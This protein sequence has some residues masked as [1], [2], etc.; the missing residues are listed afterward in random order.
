MP[1]QVLE[2]STRSTKWED[3][4]VLCPQ[5]D[6]DGSAYLGRHRERAPAGIA[7]APS[8]SRRRDVDVD[9]IVVQDQSSRSRGARGGPRRSCRSGSDRY[10]PRVADV[11]A[12]DVDD[13]VDA[14]EHRQVNRAI[15]AA[16]R[17]SRPD[18]RCP[19]Q[20]LEKSTRSRKKRTPVSRAR[21]NTSTSAYSAVCGNAR[22]AGVEQAA[23]HPRRRDV[24]VDARRSGA[25]RHVLAQHAVAPGVVVGRV[26]IVGPRVAD[27][28][29]QGSFR[30]RRRHPRASADQSC[31]RCSR[32]SSRPDSRCRTR[33]SR[34]PPA[35]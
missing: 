34:S 9:W 6:V 7:D 26:V 12:T 32:R 8:H 35:R 3:A 10:G 22:P 16:R 25:N 4:G 30:R 24:D 29:H 18:S 33:C 23:H 15:A 5:E 11:R 19:D 27:A 28:L 17:S 1:D 13:V 20:V 31:G 21:R 14:G 2:K